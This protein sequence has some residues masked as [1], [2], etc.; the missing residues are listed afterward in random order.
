MAS[1]TRI[2]SLYKQLLRESQ[3]FSQ[4]NFREYAMR[5]VRDGFAQAK[6]ESNMEKI[7]QSI[8]FG[9]ENLAIIKRQVILGQLY[10][11][12]ILIIEALK[13]KQ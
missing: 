6:N 12:N 4:Y 10:K 2:L 1:K 7:E 13:D 3:K 9:E 8:H 5:R 11:D